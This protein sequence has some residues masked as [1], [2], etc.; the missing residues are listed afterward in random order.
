MS[1]VE[2]RGAAVDVEV[3]AAARAAEARD[4]ARNI[5]RSRAV[6]FASVE[7][8]IVSAELKRR[9]GAD[10]NVAGT[11]AAAGELQRASRHIYRG[12]SAVIKFRLNLCRA[13]NVVKG[14]VVL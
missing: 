11:R 13:G 3:R 4:R 10:G 9:A 1:S 12:A 14:A 6:Q 2:L 7:T 5:D 8:I